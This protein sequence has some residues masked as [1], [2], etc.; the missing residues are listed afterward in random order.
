M[1]EESERNRLVKLIFF[2]YFDRV[3]AHRDQCSFFCCLDIAITLLCGYRHQLNV[4]LPR[5]LESTVGNAGGSLS[6][7]RIKGMLETEPLGL[8][9]DFLAFLFSTSPHIF[10]HISPTSLLSS[11]S[12]LILYLI[13]CSHSETLLN[14]LTGPHPFPTNIS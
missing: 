7:G 12:I 13:P 3:A 4:S 2:F 10:L 14:Q 1:L 5:A 6:C 9:P 8:P 11:Y